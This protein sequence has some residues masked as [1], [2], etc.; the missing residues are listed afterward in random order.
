EVVLAALKGAQMAL[1][2][3][4]NILPVLKEAGVVDAGGQGLVCIFEGMVA[5]LTA[6]AEEVAEILS[7]Q[8]VPL[9]VDTEFGKVTSE[10]TENKYCTEFIILGAEVD[11]EWLRGELESKGDSMIVVGDSDVVKVH[12]HTDQPGEVLDFCGAL[13][14]LTE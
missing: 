1:D 12:L 10:V 11:P 4:P 9:V 7:E 14:E 2:D 6:T 5:G 13:G 8:A 3:T